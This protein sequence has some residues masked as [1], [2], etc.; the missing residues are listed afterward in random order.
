MGMVYGSVDHWPTCDV[1][2]GYCSSL[3]LG[4]GE[5][6]APA[7][8]QDWRDPAMKLRHH[9]QSA[10]TAPETKLTDKER[11]LAFCCSSLPHAKSRL[12]EPDY[13]AATVSPCTGE[14]RRVK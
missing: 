2:E 6:L 9:N 5:G 4:K 8:G 11:P 10:R 7:A 3:D 12:V 14:D 13:L 1:V